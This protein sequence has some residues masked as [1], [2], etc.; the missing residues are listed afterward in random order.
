MFSGAYFKTPE[1]YSSNSMKGHSSKSS[2]TTDSQTLCP[3]STDMLQHDNAT[4]WERGLQK[5]SANK[6]NLSQ[7]SLT[8]HSSSLGNKT[9]STNLSDQNTR[10]SRKSIDRKS[11]KSSSHRNDGSF[12]KH[13]KNFIVK[14][15]NFDNF[16]QQKI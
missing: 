15:D 2:H 14:N 3:M 10:H 12:D 4:T 6:L 9:Q 1:N 11:T 16:L 7:S 13:N 5:T 8:S